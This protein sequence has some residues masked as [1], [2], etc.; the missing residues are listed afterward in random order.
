MSK[1]SYLKNLVIHAIIL[2]LM[3]YVMD[4]FYVD[5]LVS[6][7]IIAFVLSL[8]NTYIKPVLELMSWPITFLSLGIFKLLING[9]ILFLA[10]LIMGVHFEIDGA[11]VTVFAAIVFSLLSGLAGAKDD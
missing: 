4:G 9:F 10:D 8:L 7:L 6:G 1:E 5:S 3:S 11:L 2:V